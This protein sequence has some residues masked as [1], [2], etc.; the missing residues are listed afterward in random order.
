[1]FVILTLTL[2]AVEG[3]GEESP[4]FAVAIVLADLLT[5]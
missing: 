4:H 3:E 5:R 2:G 1:M